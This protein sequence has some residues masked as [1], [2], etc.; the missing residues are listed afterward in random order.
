MESSSFSWPC[1]D[2][3]AQLIREAQGADIGATER[4]LAVLRPSLVA[5]FQRRL[6]TESAD[7]LAQLASVRIVGAIDRIDPQRADGYVSTVAR[8]LLRT[9]YRR[10]ARDY[11]RDGG[12]EASDLPSHVPSAVERVEYEELVVA[13]HRACLT[14]LRPGLRE[15]AVGLL[16]GETASEIAADLGVSPIT[17]RTRLMRVRTILREELAPFLDSGE[18]VQ[19]RA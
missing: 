12:I 5:F 15:V 1:A 18:H 13:L 3:L 10:R 16:H 4:L 17:V 11:S 2:V 9:T 6:P 19:P 8:N 7:D 14:K